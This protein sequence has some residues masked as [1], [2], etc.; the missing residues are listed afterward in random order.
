MYKLNKNN[1]SNRKKRFEKKNENIHK[2]L[3]LKYKVYTQCQKIFGMDKSK[4]TNHL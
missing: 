4:K 3:K 2:L 1:S